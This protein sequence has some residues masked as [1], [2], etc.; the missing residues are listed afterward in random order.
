MSLGSKIKELREGRR[1][2]QEQL[3][4]RINKS[5][6]YITRLEN[7]E[8]RSPGSDVIAGLA[9]AFSISE[10]TL[11]E[12]AGQAPPRASVSAELE[13]FQI[14]LSG[15]QVTARDLRRIRRMVEAYLTDAE[16][17]PSLVKPNGGEPKA[18]KDDGK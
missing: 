12:A 3:A 18:D 1:W 6:V 13:D 10:R 17:D 5:R 16:E 7:D 2:T 8:Y 4:K 11:L 15:Q 9:M 14:W